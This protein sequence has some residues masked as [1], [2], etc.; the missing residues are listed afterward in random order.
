MSRVSHSENVKTIYDR[1]QQKNQTK[2]LYKDNRNYYTRESCVYVLCV[3]VCGCLCERI[4]IYICP[5]RVC[6]YMSYVCARLC[7]HT[8]VSSRVGKGVCCVA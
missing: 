1:Y 7:V 8:C 4:Y 2:N 6:V 3:W 5:T